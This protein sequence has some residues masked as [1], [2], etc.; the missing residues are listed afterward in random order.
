MYTQEN[1]MEKIL[2]LFPD[3]KPA[4]EHHL[5]YWGDDNRSIG[6]D[7]AEFFNFIA[8]KLALKEN[9]N[10]QLTFDTVEDLLVNGDRV[11]S[12]AIAM[13]FLENLL[14]RSSHGYFPIESFFNYLGKE[15]KAFCKANEEFWGIENSKFYED[16]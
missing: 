1:T 4:W 11:V 8:T 3:F 10:Y 13:E 14:N 12:E 6:I 2:L 7:I 9:Y 5:E 15:S 16:K